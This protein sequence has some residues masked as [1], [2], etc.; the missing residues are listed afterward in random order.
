MQA[1]HIVH[2]WNSG[3]AE[4]EFQFVRCACVLA[5]STYF[6]KSDQGKDTVF[7]LVGLLPTLKGRYT[8]KH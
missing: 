5:F 4:A 3:R 6:V 2:P 7:I 1:V 8:L